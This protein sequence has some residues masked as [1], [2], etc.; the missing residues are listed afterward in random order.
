[1]TDG[2]VVAI[3][4]ERLDPTPFF[5]LLFLFNYIQIQLIDTIFADLGSA[6]E[7]VISSENQFPI[8][9]E[10]GHWTLMEDRVNLF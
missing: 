6:T 9:V 8:S 3:K 4:L 10:K 2:V 1:M 7:I 5:S